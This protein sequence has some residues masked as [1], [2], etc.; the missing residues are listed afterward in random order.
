VW[1]GKTIRRGT[2]LTSTDGKAELNKIPPKD[3]VENRGDDEA[4][5]VYWCATYSHLFLFWSCLVCI[6]FQS[7]IHSGKA[8]DASNRASPFLVTYFSH[9]L[10]K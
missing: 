6:L 2:T 8:I 1:R 4:E 5:A 10:I 3:A 9:R 7:C